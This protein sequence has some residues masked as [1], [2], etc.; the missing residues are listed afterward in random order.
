MNITYEFMNGENGFYPIGDILIITYS[1]NKNT[2][3]EIYYFDKEIGY[4]Q[5]FFSAIEIAHNYLKERIKEMTEIMT[6]S[7]IDLF[8]LDIDC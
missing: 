1:D 7:D 8:D 4:T 5:N 6:K 2:D 3:Y